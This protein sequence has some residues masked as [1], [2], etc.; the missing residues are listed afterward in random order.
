MKIIDKRRDAVL[1]V[2]RIEGKEV[3]LEPVQKRREEVA[4]GWRGHRRGQATATSSR[5][6]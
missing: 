3:R 2:L 5:S 6:R 1:G 4:L